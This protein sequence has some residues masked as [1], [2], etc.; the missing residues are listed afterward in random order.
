VPERREIWFSDAT[1]GFYALRAA[2][3]VWPRGASSGGACRRPAKI[4][5]KLHRI[6]GTRV[7]R[8][9]AFANGKRVLRRTGSDVRRIELSLKRTGKLKVRIVATHNTGAKVV[10]TRSWNGCKKGRPKVRVV[11][12]P[13]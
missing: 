6:E 11:P 12:R 10:S 7:V 13:R 4:G 3:N 1:G 9:E 2:A 5:F 8:V